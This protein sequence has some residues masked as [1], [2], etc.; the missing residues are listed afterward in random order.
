MRITTRKIRRQNMFTKFKQLF[1]VI[2][3]RPQ[4]WMNLEAIKAGPKDTQWN[5]YA[6]FCCFRQKK[7]NTHK[8]SLT[9]MPL[10]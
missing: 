3:K 6:G 8:T 5:S 10:A 9:S 7:K 4:F 2:F 1:F